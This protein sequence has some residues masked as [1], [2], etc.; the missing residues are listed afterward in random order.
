MWT[1]PERK[2][3]PK[4]SGLRSGNALSPMKGTQHCWPTSVQQLTTCCVCFHGML[5]HVVTCWMLLRTFDT[6]QTFGVTS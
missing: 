3:N 2:L 1:S 4:P 6:D 5:A